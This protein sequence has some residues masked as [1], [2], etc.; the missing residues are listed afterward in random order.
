MPYGTHP[1]APTV[2]PAALGVSCRLPGMAGGADGVQN[3]LHEAERLGASARLPKG[4]VNR[5]TG[6]FGVEE[7]LKIISS[8]PCA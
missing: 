5:T 7:P 4:L 8:Q 2:G 1:M 3:L 6:C